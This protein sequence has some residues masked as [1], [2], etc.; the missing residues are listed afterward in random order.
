[1]AILTREKYLAAKYKNE[2]Q[3]AAGTYMYISQNYQQLRNF[4][5]H[6]ANERTEGLER[7]KQ[8]AKGVLSGVPDFR[9]EA[10]IKD[11]K[12]ERIQSNYI[13]GPVR[14][15]PNIVPGWYL[16]LKMLNGVLADSQK[17]LFPKWIMQGIDI[18]ICYSPAEVTVQLEKRYGLPA[19]L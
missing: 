7:I 11:Y 12:T 3:F 8:A 19:Y 16:E 5:F 4:F 14:A 15:V 2:D 17:R 9:F 1:M 13:P 10:I 18:E 6:I